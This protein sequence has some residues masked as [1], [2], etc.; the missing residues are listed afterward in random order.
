M[1]QIL[2]RGLI[3]I[4]PLT[5]TIAILVWVF[6]F[7]EDSFGKLIKAAV[8]PEYYFP[9]MGLLV[10]IVILFIFGTILNTWIME[11]LWTKGEELIQKIPLVKSL[12]SAISDAMNFLSTPKEKGL[13][14]V[15]K[16]RFGEVELVGIVTRE[17]FS[18]LKDLSS[19]DSV[20]VFFS[21]SYQIGGITAIV[22]KSKIEPIDLS[23]E[24][25]MKFLITAGAKA[26]SNNKPI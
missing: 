12:Y 15:V 2:K 5:L 26:S 13:Q 20:C 22:P 10:A 14:K 19:G 9:G 4:A 25:A 21:L 16:V 7:L 11:K 23:V 3:A 6:N 1:K 24:K 18:D 17:D 8:G